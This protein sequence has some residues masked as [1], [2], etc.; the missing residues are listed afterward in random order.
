MDEKIY[1]KL[2]EY[3]IAQTSLHLKVLDV[4][5]KLKKRQIQ[6][7]TEKINLTGEHSSLRAASC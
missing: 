3:C 7:G 1:K 5:P 2:K 4:R 6:N